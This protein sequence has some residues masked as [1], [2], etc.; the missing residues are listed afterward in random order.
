[1]GVD[2]KPF[3]NSGI[4]FHTV[5]SKNLKFPSHHKDPF[6]HFA[7]SNKETLNEVLNDG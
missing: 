4:P 6:N 3:F 2:L 5:N 1:M 7:I